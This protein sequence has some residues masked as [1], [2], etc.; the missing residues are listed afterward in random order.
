MSLYLQNDISFL[1]IEINYSLWY[2]MYVKNTAV[3][4]NRITKVVAGWL[5]LAYLCIVKKKKES[6]K[7]NKHS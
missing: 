7:G 4:A 5:N 6:L 1:L 3:N 2:L